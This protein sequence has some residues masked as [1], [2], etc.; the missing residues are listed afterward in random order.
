[1]HSCPSCQST[2]IIRRGTYYNKTDDVDKQRLS[3]NDCETHFSVELPK[4]EQEPIAYSGN[5]RY[6]ITSCQNDTLINKDFYQSLLTYC[7]H[8]DAQLMVLRV[9]YKIEDADDANYLVNPEYILKHNIIIADKIKVFGGLSLM[10]TL[11]SP[12]SG[13]DTFSAGYTCVF[14]HTTYQMRSLPVLS[15]QHPIIMTTTGSI[16]LPNNSDTKTGQ[17]ADYN[18]SFSAL[19]IEVEKDAFHM[20]IV[21]A[22]DT[23]GFYDLTKYYSQSDVSDGHRIDALVLGDVHVDVADKG[24]IAATYSNPD[25]V[26]NT[27]KP[28]KV[29]L[30]DLL[31]FHQL[32]S[33]H[34][35]NNYLKRYSMYVS[36][37]DD[38]E[39]ELRRTMQFV[40]DNTPDFVEENLVVSANH[41][42]HLEHFLNST[43]IKNDYKNSVI[44]H[45]LMYK[46]LIAIN[47]N[48]NV[49]AFQL[50][51]E[52]FCED[53]IVKAKT[54]F[55]GREESYFIHGILISSHGDKGLNGSRF[56]PTQSK[57]F[58]HPM[59]VGHAHSICV[60]QNLFVAGTCTGKLDYAAGSPSGWVN[61]HVVIYPNGTRTH[62]NIIHKK[63]RMQ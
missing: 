5:K 52:D 44:Y 30:H 3:C 61:S 9:K 27:L 41:L 6:V 2:N 4:I 21:T 19:V 18:H 1:M 63:W 28:R 24:V 51:F 37:N 47:N 25:S 36:G 59:I 60:E 32:G 34:N 31:D 58:P 13:M 23:G 26:V 39:A 49:N 48:R 38:V 12:L 43:D 22:D 42:D 16:S 45:F 10:P 8:N 57:K 62:I 56:S 53:D 55:L 20:R 46:M 17:K 33:H 14:G 7:E 15:D 40:I 11:V 50:F 35:R 29:V 54:K